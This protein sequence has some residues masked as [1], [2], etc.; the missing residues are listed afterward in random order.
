MYTDN[1]RRAEK[2]RR[3]LETAYTLFKTKSVNATAVDDVVKAA[4]IA[5]GTFYLYFKDKTDLLDQIVFLK[6]TE[7]MKALVSDVERRIGDD[8]MDF[9]SGC[10][11][12]LDMYIDFLQAHK[13]VLTVVEKNLSACLKTFPSFF[14]SEAA[15][16]YMKITERFIANGFTVD[17]AHKTVY[18]VVDMVGSVCSD[19]ILYER[20]FALNEIRARVTDAAVAVIKQGMK[21]NTEIGG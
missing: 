21:Q 12:F 11:L 9:I 7:S 18:I 15:A 17:D 10:R 4:G 19:A 13:D 16:Q 1:D 14:D 8:S 20:P 6:S 2:K 3:I 5:R